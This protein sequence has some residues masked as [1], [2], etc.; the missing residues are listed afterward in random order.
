MQLQQDALS[1][2][3]SLQRASSF[4]IVKLQAEIKELHKWL[5][6]I[7]QS[8]FHNSATAAQEKG[9]GEWLIQHPQFKRWINGTDRCLVIY[10]RVGCGKTILCAAIANHMERL[11]RTRDVSNHRDLTARFYFSFENFSLQQ[12]LENLLKSIIQ[13]LSFAP[14][15]FSRLK[16][17]YE[18]NTKA[19]PPSS[20]SVSRLQELLCAGLK[21]RCS[22]VKVP[23]EAYLIIDALDEIPKGIRRTEVIKFLRDLAAL[24]I[25][26]LHVLVT[27][28]PKL[29]IQAP[30]SAENDAWAV[31]NV[32]VAAISADI[33]IFVNAALDTDFVPPLSDDTKRNV[34]KRLTKDQHGM[35]RWAKLQMESLKRLEPA[36]S[37]SM[38]I[39]LATLPPDLNSSYLQ[40][41]EGINANFQ[42]QA[43]LV[44]VWLCL[45]SRPLYIEEVVEIS[46][47]DP[48]G[49]PG[50]QEARRFEQQEYVEQILKDLIVI[51]PPLDRLHP[52]QRR[53][54]VRLGHFSVR[55]YLTGTDILKSAA[56]IFS[57]SPM[58]D[59]LVAQ[60]CLV[61]LFHNNSNDKSE[62]A[63]CLREYAWNQWA[64]H[65][66][67]MSVSNR[68][69]K[70]ME[71]FDSC[72]YEKDPSEGFA[73]LRDLG[74]IDWVDPDSATENSLL[75][76]ALRNPWSY[77][78]F[79]LHFAFPLNAF[80]YKPLQ[81][82][83]DI[84]VVRILPSEYDSPEIRCQ[85][86]HTS[87][88]D[89][90]KYDAISYTWRHYGRERNSYI[91]LGGQPFSVRGKIASILRT[92]R[93]TNSST[94]IDVWID[95]LCINMP[96]LPERSSQVALMARIYRQAREVAVIL[97][98]EGVD[99]AAFHIL[100][101]LSALLDNDDVSEPDL[102]RLGK[103]VA[104]YDSRTAWNIILSLFSQPWWRRMWP[105]QEIVLAS[106]A[107]IIYGKIR[108]GFDE[109]QKVMVKDAKA[110]RYLR[111]VYTDREVN[112]T[113][114]FSCSD[115][116]WAGARAL[117]E[118]RMTMQR[119]GR[120]ELPHLLYASRFSGVSFTPDRIFSIY[121][122]S[123]IGLDPEAIA[124]GMSVDY[125][126]SPEMVFTSCSAYLLNQYC[127]LDQFS[128]IERRCGNQV[129]ELPSWASTF[130]SSGDNQISDH[131]DDD[132]PV[133]NSTYLTLPRRLTPRPLVKGKFQPLEGEDLYLACGTATK[134][135]IFFPF[136]DHSLVIR[137]GIVVDQVSDVRDFYPY[138]RVHRSVMWRNQM[139]TRAL[140]FYISNFKTIIPEIFWRTIVA[141][142]WELGSR[143]SLNCWP[144]WDLNVRY[145]MLSL[146]EY[147]VPSGFEYAQS[148]CIFK[149]DSTR[150]GLGPPNMRADDYIVVLPGG[151]VPFVFRRV[152]E[153]EYISPRLDFLTVTTTRLPEGSK[154][155]LIGECYVHGIMDGEIMKAAEAGEYEFQDVRIV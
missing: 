61:Y 105:I 85:M 79:R 18:E 154:L 6:P 139:L 49:K 87:L 131:G 124:P 107:T 106:K 113:A 140:D 56:A 25:P 143:S 88:E 117:G 98:D 95:G 152:Y 64:W 39:T 26:F 33:G 97:E 101:E 9:T 67:F 12:N 69:E 59:K 89:K 43:Q 48:S 63:Y 151:K 38:E 46:A 36:S 75:Q 53:N 30:L 104:R 55:E 4:D 73:S 78:D 17:L 27:S 35:F 80:E 62:K 137:K 5:E 126:L 21:L 24:R 81:S 32:D 150:L 68:S 45:A 138:D 76:S 122:L 91:R 148:R 116:V 13:Q 123:L 145:G 42:R 66:V 119:D 72:V 153:G 86:V 109:I 44:L 149:T 16:E 142:Q 37:E 130:M 111:Q 41:L 14:E 127:N 65:S 7:D 146:P 103:V 121:P 50:F 40:I 92:L 10:G 128:Y 22:E 93:S 112:P 57:V 129:Y 8:R 144:S 133:R 70:A 90:P 58:A 23:R 155:R 3:T 114:A 28:R 31:L 19:W 71:L 15:I 110:N 47:T 147:T 60:S 54:I 102:Q 82:P 2:T 83:S 84:R 74:L 34:R 11:C 52:S 1:Q 141:D 29:D 132:V 77:R 136:D 118:L 99:V 125:S 108:V 20:P 96:D 51:D 100:G 135:N 94:P 120:L 134:A 115:V